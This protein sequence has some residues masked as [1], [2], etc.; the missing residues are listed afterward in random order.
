M[1]RIYRGMYAGSL[2]GAGPKVFG[3]WGWILAHEQEGFCEV[4]PVGVANA[5]GGITVPEVE[6]AIA[7]LAVDGRLDP[8][9]G[10]YYRVVNNE[11]I[12]HQKRKAL[13]A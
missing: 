2:A 8:I 7:F 4:H 10:F 6:E 12:E 13:K 5:L 9:W 3:V 11:E 1:G